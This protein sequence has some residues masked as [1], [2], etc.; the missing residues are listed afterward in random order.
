MKF[1]I[2][3]AY[4]NRK[5][6]LQRTLDKFET[7]YVDKYDFEVVIVDDNS[8]KHHEIENTL[9]KYSFPIELLRVVTKRKQRKIVNP[10]RRYSRIYIKKFN[11]GQ[12]YKLCLLFF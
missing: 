9:A 11:K 3:M 8:D 12:L 5:K 2:V 6:L 1:S 7:D 10:G 4:H